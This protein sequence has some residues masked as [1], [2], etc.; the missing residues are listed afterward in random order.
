MTQ[1]IRQLNRLTHHYPYEPGKAVRQPLAHS[2]SLSISLY[3]IWRG[4]ASAPCTAE[5][6]A[7]AICLEGTAEAQREVQMLPLCAGQCLPLPAGS[8]FAFR[9]KEN[10]KLLLIV[11]E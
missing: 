4:S 6:E 8:R 3:A 7:L 5:G 2:A 11:A 9:G 10:C 1:D